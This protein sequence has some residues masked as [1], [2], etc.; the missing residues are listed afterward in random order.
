MS[1]RSTAFARLTIVALIFSALWMGWRATPS[2]SSSR[3]TLPQPPLETPVP[4]ELYLPIISTENGGTIPLVTPTFTPT[5]TVTATVTPAVSPTPTASPTP[6]MKLW[7]GVHL[8]NKSRNGLSSWNETELQRIDPDH[9]TYGQ[10]AIWPSMIVVLSNQVY[11]IVRAN[12]DLCTIQRAEIR[13]PRMFDYLRRA[14]QAGS[15]VVIRIYPSPGNFEDWAITDP[16]DPGY[17]Q[18]RTL[19]ADYPVGGDNCQPQFYRSPQDLA[20]EMGA[21]HT[22]NLENGFSE[23][24]FEPAN[25]P[26]IEW[27]DSIVSRPEN[28][29]PEVWVAMNRYFSRIYELAGDEGYRIFTP[30]MAQ[31]QFADGIDLISCNERY[32]YSETDQKVTG[33]WRM[34]ELLGQKSHGFS[35]HNYWDWGKE[36]YVACEEGGQH[37]S[38]HFPQWMR[39]LLREMGKPVILSEADLFSPLQ[40]ASAPIKD[41]NNADYAS[42][43]EIAGSMQQFFAAEWR[44]GGY[45]DD[46]HYGVEPDLAIWLLND[47]ICDE[48]RCP[49]DD[50]C[51]QNYDPD[52]PGYCALDHNWHEAYRDVGG[53]LSVEREWFGLWYAGAEEP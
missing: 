34:Q 42:P 10:G 23:F 53:E 51:L 32:L 2:L 7:T 52:A 48:G 18:N 19:V 3:S 1:K 27:Y 40:L 8:G 33:Y 17:R 44:D 9:P 29:K 31:S 15:K 20:D 25:E 24:G 5:A 38:F 13:L 4:F 41:K 28:F 11:N 16:A 39:D 26:N 50:S 47:N 30:P 21:I 14:T 43:A 37:I 45:G 22:L 36:D 49:A 35:W 12:D 6:A 46:S